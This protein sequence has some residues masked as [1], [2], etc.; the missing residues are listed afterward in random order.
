MFT[1]KIVEVLDKADCDIMSHFK[2]TN[3]YIDQVLA[4]DEKHKVLIHCFA[5]KSRACSF[6]AAYLVGKK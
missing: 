5:G 3:A 1:Y 4:E 2:E 6:T